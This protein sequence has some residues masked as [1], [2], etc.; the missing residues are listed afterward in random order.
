MGLYDSRRCYGWISI[1]LHWLTAITVFALFAVGLWMVDLDYYSNWYKQAP[2]LHKSV[3]VILILTVV[4]RI[5]WRIKN[6]RPETP[7]SHHRWEKSSAKI[8]HFSLYALLLFMLPS[9]YLITTAK[10]QGLDVFNWFTIPSLIS[11][12]DNLEDIAGELHEL[13]AFGI[14]AIATLHGLGA[15]KHHFIDKDNTLRRMLGLVK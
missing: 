9:G 7:E 5:C 1:I 11:G 2:H 3:G 15:L 8:A 6:V 4:F 14:I 12:V 10:G 13:A